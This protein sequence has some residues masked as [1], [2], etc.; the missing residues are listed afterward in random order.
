MFAARLFGV[1][2]ILLIA[3]IITDV[4]LWDVPDW[5][6]MLVGLPMVM[7]VGL[8]GLGVIAQRV[9]QQAR[10]RR[11]M[12]AVTAFCVCIGVILY[13][14]SAAFVLQGESVSQP[15]II[16][17]LAVFFIPFLISLFISAGI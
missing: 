11:P 7:S 2:C 13:G 4:F 17:T 3:G 5:L 9:P 1:S 6:S 16:A 15:M 14:I 10:Y 8:L 12:L